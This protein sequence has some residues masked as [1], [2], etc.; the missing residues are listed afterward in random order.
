MKVI[1][2]VIFILVLLTGCDGT[3]EQSNISNTDICMIRKE[4]K[5]VVHKSNKIVPVYFFTYKSILSKRGTADLIH[6]PQELHVVLILL[7]RITLGIYKHEDPAILFILAPI[8]A[9]STYFLRV[10]K[11]L[12]IT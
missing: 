5:I 3:M 7:R 10:R 12:H 2:L 4:I 6:Y 11:Y 9:K 1:T 8:K